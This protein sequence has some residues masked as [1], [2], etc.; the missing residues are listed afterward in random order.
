MILFQRAIGKQVGVFLLLVGAAAFLGWKNMRK[1]RGDRHGAF[2]LALFAFAAS[3]GTWLCRAN[4]VPDVS[5]IASIFSAVIFNGFFTAAGW[6]VY[7]A[8]EPYVRRRWPHAI[9]S[10]TRLL[11]G[12]FR[13]PMV[14]GHVLLGLTWGTALAVISTAALAAAG[15]YGLRNASGWILSSSSGL[16]SQFLALAWDAV[17]RG[18]FVLFLALVFKLL[19]RNE[20]IA[21]AC[22]VAVVTAVTF[23]FEVPASPAPAAAVIAI[24]VPVV[25]AMTYLVLR[26]GLLPVIAAIYAFAL[27]AGAPVSADLSAP[28]AA[29]AIIVLCGVGALA[30]LAFRWTVAAP[31]SPTR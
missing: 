31:S 27:L 5:E 20:W 19:F 1:G 17:F 8:L 6:I 7:I 13:D 24:V 11:S 26:T 12:N 21:G 2:R 22:I 9:I 30:L 25:V 15:V 29:A 10:W 14:G 18:L 3:F 4:H 16:V 28:G 23:V